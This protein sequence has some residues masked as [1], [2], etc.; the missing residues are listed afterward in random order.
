VGAGL[1][2]VVL[3]VLQS[4]TSS[5]LFGMRTVTE[6]STSTVTTSVTAT[7]TSISP[8]TINA[9]EVI[10]AFAN[11]LILITT[12]NVSAIDSGYVDSPTVVWKGESPSSSG[13]LSGSNVNGPNVGI[14]WSDFFRGSSATSLVLGNETYHVAA[15]GGIYVVNSD[16]GFQGYGSETGK[17]NGTISGQDSYVRV[18]NT[19]LISNETLDFISF[20]EQSVTN[21]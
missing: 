15:V 4:M 10:A 20:Y 8:T 7:A 9:S 14:G 18:G 1:A 3:L 2:L 11:H 17:F 5:G 21:G 19:W 16:F 6:T 12:L 13:S